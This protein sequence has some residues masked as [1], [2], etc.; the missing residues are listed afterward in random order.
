MQTIIKNCE[1]VNKEVYDLMEIEINNLQKKANGVIN[2]I[3]GV[4]SRKNRDVYY[5][6]TRVDVILKYNNILESEDIVVDISFLSH[7][8]YF[9]LY[10]NDI[11]LNS[12]IF[13]YDVYS[14]DIN[15]FYGA[16]CELYGGSSKY[17]KIMKD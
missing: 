14:Y 4:L 9:N 16:I 8:F 12:F 6:E 17:F 2:K 3:S 1:T 11:P 10:K 7:S 15:N 5:D 13:S